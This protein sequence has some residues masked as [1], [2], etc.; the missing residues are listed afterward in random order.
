V[1]DIERPWRD[2]PTP[3]NEDAGSESKPTSE[4]NRP[5]ATGKNTPAGSGKSHKKCWWWLF[6]IACALVVIGVSITE[7][8][9]ADC[10][11]AQSA[12]NQWQRSGSMSDYGTFRD[13]DWKCKN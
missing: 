3:S 5:Y 11:F 10:A 1:S 2:N 4:W 8:G 12:Y 7:S 9:V 13:Y 6:G